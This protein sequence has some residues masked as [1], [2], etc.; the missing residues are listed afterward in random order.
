M[1]H[2]GPI[3]DYLDALAGELAFDPALSYR[4]R[5]EAEDHLR[6]AAA[7]APDGADG[8][9]G[10]VANFGEPRA[11]AREYAACALLARTRRVGVIMVL[12]LAG[13]FIA[14]T[15]RIAWYG[16]TQWALSDDLKAIN[17]IAVPLDRYAFMFALATA[18]VA[19]GYI[20][21][22]R[23]PREFHRAYGRELNRCA[24]L[25]AAAAAALLLSVVIET[26]LTV[27]RLLVA[28]WSARAVIPLLSM[29]AE[30][31]FAGVLVGQIRAALRRASH[32][33][34]LFGK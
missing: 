4:V 31:T 21:S 25:C 2:C 24:L 18:I 28:E 19:C 30:I 22:R 15:G 9:R 6:E 10:A 13:V 34:I 1:R 27:F 12:A 14:M 23:A 29:A 7:H 26:V 5:K 8:E 33:S 32:A 17:A 3:A 11:L 20:A 16:F